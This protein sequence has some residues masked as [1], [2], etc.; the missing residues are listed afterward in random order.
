[1]LLERAQ[2]RL[3][4]VEHWVHQVRRLARPECVLDS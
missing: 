1:M 4:C 2:A 3:E